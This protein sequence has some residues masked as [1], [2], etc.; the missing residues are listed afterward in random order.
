M[1]D[2]R[3][4]CDLKH[5]CVGFILCKI[6]HFLRRGFSLS[7]RAGWGRE[8]HL[9]PEEKWSALSSQAHSY[10]QA[11]IW[12]TQGANLFKSRLWF[13]AQTHE[14]PEHVCR[15]WRECRGASCG[16]WGDGVMPWRKQ[17]IERSSG[18]PG[19]VVRPFLKLPRSS[20][21]FKCWRN[22]EFLSE[23]SRSANVLSL[24]HL[25]S[26]HHTPAPSSLSSPSQPNF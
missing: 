23:S 10:S 16:I 3:L 6:R 4:L 11:W 17:H 5:I 1:W 14:D 26:P 13:L 24:S 19:L 8:P 22:T 18:S 25:Q 12:K 21:S 7:Q 20:F 15:T 9:M 2:A